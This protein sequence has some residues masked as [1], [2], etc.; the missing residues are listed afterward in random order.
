MPLI[1]DNPLSTVAWHWID[2]ELTLC[3]CCDSE[4]QHKNRGFVEH[5]TRLPI[6]A[7]ACSKG[8][9]CDLCYEKF[10]SVG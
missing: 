4:Y 7:Q 8:D 9:Q 10:L 3:D 2:H 5:L 6:K 1:L